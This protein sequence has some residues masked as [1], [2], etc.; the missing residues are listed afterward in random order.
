MPD[1][2]VIV[3]SPEE[4]RDHL[5]DEVA[6]NPFLTGASL[7]AMTRI[8]DGAEVRVPAGEHEVWGTVVEYVNDG[9]YVVRIPDGRTPAFD[10]AT[11]E[12]LNP[13]APRVP[14]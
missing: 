8:A 2:G 10:G 3:F 1:P 9:G 6:K 13:D 7:V 4:L 11:L 5:Q 14:V 12:R